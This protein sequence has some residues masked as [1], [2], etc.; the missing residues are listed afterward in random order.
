MVSIYI[1][2]YL[3]YSSFIEGME[4][5]DRVYRQALFSSLFVRHG[6]HAESV[7]ERESQ[8]VYLHDGERRHMQYVL[9]V[10]PRS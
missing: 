9:S 1:Y 7:Y 3:V 4:P 5:P 2:I 6:G 10:H 8:P